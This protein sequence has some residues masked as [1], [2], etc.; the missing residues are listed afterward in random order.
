MAFPW[1]MCPLEYFKEKRDA[2]SVVNVSAMRGATG[3][4]ASIV[5]A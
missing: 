2:P 3:M 5:L 1:G 4:P